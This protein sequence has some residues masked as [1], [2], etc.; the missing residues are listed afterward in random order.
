MSA[1]PEKVKPL[2]DRSLAA[3]DQE[4]FQTALKRARH[5]ANSTAC[6]APVL[7]HA[8]TEAAHTIW[9][10]VEGSEDELIPFDP[11]TLQ[12]VYDPAVTAAERW[13]LK[14]HLNKI[15]WKSRVSKC[16]V[17]KTRNVERQVLRRKETRRA[18]LHGFQTC[19]SPH[20]CTICGPKISERRKV[21]LE[22]AMKVAQELGLVVKMGTF[23][24]PHGMGDDLGDLFESMLGAWRIT[25]T[26][27]AGKALRQKLRLVGYIRVLETTDGPNGFHPHF[28][29][30]FF[31]EEDC[32][33]EAVKEAFLPI[34]RNAVVKKG[35]GLISDKFGV[36]VQGADKAAAYVSKGSWSIAHEMAKGNA[37]K[38]RHGGDSM[39]DL[40]RKSAEGCARSTLRFKIYAEAIHGKRHMY[41]SQGLKKLLRV[42][43]LTDEE[44]AAKAEEGIHDTI[45]ASL[46]DED[47]DVLAR[48]GKGDWSVFLEICGHG[49]EAAR[50]FIDQ[51]HAAEAKNGLPAATPASD[52]PQ[53]DRPLRIKAD[54][55]G[56]GS[57]L[58]ARSEGLHR[59]P[60][61]SDQLLLGL[62][63]RGI[64]GR[65]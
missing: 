15:L 43:D 21:E 2:T 65:L 19:G 28:H 7:I 20:L 5:A 3:R 41:W 61:R 13:K 33:D 6:E 48:F 24:T 46:P 49:H 34:W 51:L 37:K 17:L 31:F 52:R 26:N 40:L 58:P 60:I 63:E 4:G 55:P 42:A 56:I 57:P 62:L 64:P 35:L 12:P 45:F 39:M 32:T 44:L 47:W 29:V 38:A 30:L 8:E 10:R 22:G 27:R 1:P 16:H 14:R 59:R 50:F 54:R 53:Q 11:E 36:Q 18:F 23:T 9:A 25:S